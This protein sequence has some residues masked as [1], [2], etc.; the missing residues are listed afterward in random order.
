[1]LFGIPHRDC[2]RFP[3]ASILAPEG[4]GLLRRSVDSAWRRARHVNR[5]D[6]YA[7]GLRLQLA[8]SRFPAVSAIFQ[9]KA[10]IRKALS[11]YDHRKLSSYDH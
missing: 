2:G 6:T 9:R 5:I 11:S 8:S 3:D 7:L 1:M 10:S 4:A